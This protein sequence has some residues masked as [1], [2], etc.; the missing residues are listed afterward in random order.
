[1]NLFHEVD[2]VTTENFCVI[3]HSSNKKLS[4]RHSKQSSAAT[5]CTPVHVTHVYIFEIPKFYHRRDFIVASCSLRMVLSPTQM[6]HFEGR[7]DIYCVKPATHNQP[8]NSSLVFF[9]PLF[10]SHH[11]TYSHTYLYSK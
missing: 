1:M 2:D 11:V 10:A 8:I 3:R 4:V 9:I 6:H 7:L 5:I